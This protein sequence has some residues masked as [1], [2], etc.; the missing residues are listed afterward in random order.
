MAWQD[1]A[2]MEERIR[3][4][5]EATREEKGITALCREF[6]ISRKTGYKWVARYRAGGLAGCHD[7]SRRPRTS[8]TRIPAAVEALVFRLHPRLR[9]VR[10][11]PCL[12]NVLPMSVV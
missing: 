9:R 5:V 1:V 3:F 6:G 4:V 10:C 2:P 12:W 7:R 11:N 8:P